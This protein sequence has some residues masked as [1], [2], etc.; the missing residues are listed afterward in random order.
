MLRTILVALDE[1]P[2]CE[3]A[4]TLAL[5]WGGRFGARL[6]G[7][8]IFDKEAIVGRFDPVPPGASGFKQ[9]ADKARLIRA[10]EYL[11]RSIRK[12]NER[13]SAAGISTDTVKDVGDPAECILRN[14]QCCDV[15]I[16]GR[17]TYFHFETQEHS[18]PT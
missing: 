1:S 13:C 6:I 5:E 16:L 4:T 2:W 7:L 17:E 11:Q 18:D 15:V 9:E 12:F 8:G 3:A 14:A 10:Q